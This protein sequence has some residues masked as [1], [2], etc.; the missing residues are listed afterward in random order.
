MLASI[1]RLYLPYISPISRLLL[2]ARVD[3]AAAEPRV[4]AVAPHV[5]TR[6]ARRARARHCAGVVGA[7]RH[8]AAVAPLE[9]VDPSGREARLEAT[10]PQLAVVPRAPAPRLVTWSGLGLGLGLG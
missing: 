8:Q 7:A 5:H 4:G 2:G 3:A 9:L 1:S 10:H 6:A